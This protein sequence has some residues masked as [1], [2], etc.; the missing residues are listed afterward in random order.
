M[1]NVTDKMTDILIFQ[2]SFYIKDIAIIFHY[3]SSGLGHPLG[4]PLQ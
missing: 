4:Q 2:L 1:K 3:R